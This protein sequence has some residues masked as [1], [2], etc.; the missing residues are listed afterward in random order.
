MKKRTKWTLVCMLLPGH[1]FE[2]IL[3]IQA[4]L[5]WVH[6]CLLLRSWNLIPITLL[7]PRL[8]DWVQVFLFFIFPL[9]TISLLHGMPVT[10][11]QISIKS[12]LLFVCFV[13]L[14]FN[15]PFYHTAFPS[16][17]PFFHFLLV[18]L[19]P[20]SLCICHFLRPRSFIIYS[21]LDVTLKRACCWR[22]IKFRGT[23]FH[24]ALPKQRFT[25]FPVGMRWA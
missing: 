6:S 9:E 10:K 21:G 8:L 15:L 19:I 16:H 18:T 1:V 5:V 23:L 22:W 3:K 20:F 11:W 14:L 25:A 13:L 4:S 24:K 2:I 17:A 7:W 12:R